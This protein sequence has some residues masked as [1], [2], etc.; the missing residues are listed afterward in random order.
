MAGNRNK[1]ERLFLILKSHHISINVRHTLIQFKTVHRLHYSRLH[2]MYPKTSPLCD[3]IKLDTGTLTHQSWSRPE[4]NSSK[5]CNKTIP[6]KPFLAIFSYQWRLI[7]P[8]I[9][10]RNRPFPSL[11][12]WQN[13]PPAG[14]Q[15]SGK[16]ETWPLCLL[17]DIISF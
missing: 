2:A 4:L 11:Q 17:A 16:C 3:K 1:Y 10:L 5:A 12:C 14:A 6:P 8:L 13:T 9:N 15:R 7:T